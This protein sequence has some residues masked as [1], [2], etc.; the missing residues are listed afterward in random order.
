M[1]AANDDDDRTFP[2]DPWEDFRAEEREP[3]DLDWL[4]SLPLAEMPEDISIWVVDN[5]FPDTC[6]T[7]KGEFIVCRLEDHI[8]TKYWKHKYSAYAFSNAMR[9]AV[10]R[11]AQEG[12]AF[13]NPSVDDED[14]H[15][16]IRWS[17]AMPRETPASNVIASVKDAFDLVYA[18]AESILDNS[19]SVLVLGKD[20]GASLD[21]LRR[22]ASK[23]E[24]LGYYTYIVK[25]QPDKLG[26]GVIQKV[27]R[28]ALIC[29]FVV[30]ENTEPSGHLYEIPHVAK[31]AECVT[32]FLHEKG[33][34]ATWM[35][36]DAYA[37]HPHWKKFQYELDHLEATVDEAVAW[38]EGNVE[39]FGLYQQNVLP[40]MRT[41]KAP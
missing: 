25:D 29:K 33:K 40:W 37:K 6:I 18:R 34:G 23:L 35:F 31:S 27:M 32:A 22:I 10:Q 38:A 12:F 15:I 36:E 5:Y 4:D 9:R 41:K 11:M 20:T 8:Y 13:S 24:E 26:E 7:R 19:D 21:T 2:G 28:F 3:V 16:Y 39:K 30:V 14:V 1:T 17:L